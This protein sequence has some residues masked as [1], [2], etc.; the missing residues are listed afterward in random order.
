MNEMEKQFT[1]AARA[2]IQAAQEAGILQKRLAA[3]I[4][5]HGAVSCAKR[6]LQRG[7]HSDGFETL[8]AAGL[9]KHSLEALVISS[10][11]GALFTDEEVNQC[12]AALCGAGFY[13]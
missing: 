6:L 7:Q 3:E 11:F 10:K 8:Q 1:A 5:K 2:S 13:G 12:F 9:L 4:E